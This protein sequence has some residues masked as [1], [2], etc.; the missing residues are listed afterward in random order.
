MTPDKAKGWSEMSDFLQRYPPAIITPREF[1]EWVADVLATGGEQLDDLRVEI[2]ERVDGMDGTYDFDA[3]ARYRGP[4]L[5]S[6][7]SWK[8]SDTPIRSSA[9]SS[10]FSTRRCRASAHTRE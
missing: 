10:K 3:T 2:H 8:R 1:E 6:S 4:V 5:T 9:S 7:W